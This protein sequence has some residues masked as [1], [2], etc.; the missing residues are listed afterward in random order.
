MQPSLLNQQKWDAN[1]WENE[2]EEAF[3]NVLNILFKEPIL[4]LPD[5]EKE[6]VLKTDASGV[7]FGGALVQ[8]HDSIEHPVSFFSG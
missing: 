3:V 5:Y 7:G 6:F 1:F 2:Q 4:K 8:V